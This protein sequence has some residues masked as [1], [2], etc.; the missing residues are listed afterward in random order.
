MSAAERGASDATRA[1]I[2]RFAP[3][4]PDVERALFTA[5]ERGSVEGGSV[6]KEGRVW[7][8]GAVVIKRY[9]AR[10]TL[11]GRLRSPHALRAARAAEEI[12]AERT[13]RALAAVWENGLL[14]SGA[15]VLATEHVEGTDLHRALLDLD[16]PAMDAFP[17]FLAGLHE[18]GI[19]HGDLHPWQLLWNGERWYLLDLDGLRHPLR[20]MRRER[21]ELDAWARLLFYGRVYQL[22]SVESSLAR[23]FPRYL[24]LRRPGH[25][26]LRAW[27]HVEE[28]AAR[29][30]LSRR[31]ATAANE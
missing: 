25:D 4:E 14:L 6:L 27:A 19:H 20:A 12:G 5:L 3:L 24:E 7:R 8:L 28:L 10:Q 2:L 22:P 18:R 9:P 13:P 31:A 11:R 1:R 29:F 23:L 16:E 26:P 15:S 17:V 30:A 21:L